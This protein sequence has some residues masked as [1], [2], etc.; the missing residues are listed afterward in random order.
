[1]CRTRST[2]AGVCASC[3]AASQVGSLPWDHSTRT[4]QTCT[5]CHAERPG[6]VPPIPHALTNR[7]VCTECHAPTKDAGAGN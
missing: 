1:M 2:S 6:G 3:H 7:A 5:V 4:D